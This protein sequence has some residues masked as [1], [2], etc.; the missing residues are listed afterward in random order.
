MRMKWLLMSVVFVSPM[1][2]A[3]GCATSDD[4]EAYATKDE[5]SAYATKADLEALRSDLMAEIQKAQEDAAAAAASAEQAAEDARNASEKAE[6]IFQ[7]SLR[8]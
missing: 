1:L 8:K 2:L 4:L 6:A 5:L 3:T 7:K